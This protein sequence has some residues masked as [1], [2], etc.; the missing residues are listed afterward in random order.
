MQARALKFIKR[1]ET[2]KTET[3]GR[4]TRPDNWWVALGHLDEVHYDGLK[5]ITLD[6]LQKMNKEVYRE[7]SSRA[8]HHLLYLI[9]PQNSDDKV[10]PADEH[11]WNAD[12]PFMS[13][14]R[15][16]FSKATESAAQ[17][18]EIVEHFNKT[19]DNNKYKTKILW[20][21]YYTLELSDM[22]LVSK[23]DNFNTLINW[24]LNE[25]RMA[26]VSNAYT[27][28]C[29]SGKLINAPDMDLRNTDFGSIEFLEMRFSL[30][31]AVQ[32][33]D[34][35]AF[36]CF[37][38]NQKT[39]IE[40]IA[41]CLNQKS[42]YLISGVEDIIVC[43]KDVPAANLIEIYQD[44]YSDNLS[45]V[46]CAF[47]NIITRIGCE[48]SDSY[49]NHYPPNML[50]A[51]TKKLQD[52][53]CENDSECLSDGYYC[54]DTWK[55]PLRGL[56]NAM[57]YISKSA[58]L[59]EPVYLL[60]PSLSAFWRHVFAESENLYDSKGFYCK[61][62]ELSIHTFEHLLRAEGQLSQYPEIR[63][64]SYD[65]PV[66][67]LEYAYA[68]LLKFNRLLTLFDENEN[69]KT[70]FL[71]TPN[72]EY[73]VITREIFEPFNKIPGVLAI[74]F[75]FS[76]FYNTK[77]LLLS[78][79]HEVSHYV[80]ETLRNREK[81]YDM[82]L[83]CAA[84]EIMRYMFA[85]AEQDPSEMK[86]DISNM[87]RK[88]IQQIYEPE[89][90]NY[91]SKPVYRESLNKLEFYVGQTVNGKFV[92]YETYQNTIKNY[93]LNRKT[94]TAFRPIKKTEYS[95]HIKP[96]FERISDF[97]NLLRETYADMC[98][99]FFLKPEPIDYLEAALNPIQ[100]L[101]TSTY[102]RI[103]IGLSTA[104]YSINEITDA[105][106]AWMIK[107]A[108][109]INACPDSNDTDSYTNEMYIAAEE[110]IKK[111]ANG[112][113][114]ESLYTESRIKKYIKECWIFLIKNYGIS[115]P[116][117]PNTRSLHGEITELRNMLKLISEI[118]KDTGY[119]EISEIIDEWR[120][121]LMKD[122]GES[123]NLINAELN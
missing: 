98:M 40:E 58:T 85:D 47:P 56:T 70:T 115:K 44:W 64:L 38:N 13:I 102:I 1:F 59:Y 34:R 78:L 14:V 55:R 53:I 106:I 21:A 20:H 2:D 120:Q 10:S 87:L 15:I 74:T 114:N 88:S 39:R 69:E 92:D 33:N 18:T 43:S 109:G 104:G 101:N 121:T 108:Y 117:A 81:R 61:F 45:T 19:A 82:L 63:P 5:N 32:E 66:F 94:N 52:Y 71:L 17:F 83:D 118:N 67:I 35:I 72:A 37:P 42:A 24:S 116:D 22:I 75:P 51:Y 4:G 91:E 99:L 28:F 79:C 77:K 50:Y 49:E 107:F 8:Y 6:N 54:D 93:V 84:Y 62:S 89:E 111:L 46:K 103:Y 73:D 41:Q 11:F 7:D 97:V 57:V 68:F 123:Y 36:C 27:C 3:N 119:E 122:F 30:P 90:N 105:L 31:S 95:K 110:K 113:E 86:T 23:S 60:F 29:I 96:L 48:F 76:L 12:K 112:I 100:E 65:I 16:H 26:A 25:T 9:I 80:G